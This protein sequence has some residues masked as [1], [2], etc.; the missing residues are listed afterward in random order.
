MSYSIFQ[1]NINSYD[2]P[3]PVNSTG[4]NILFTDEH[5]NVNGWTEKIIMPNKNPFNTV[6][7]IRWHLLNYTDD[8]YAI[9]TDGSIEIKNDP[10]K[11]IDLMKNS[12]SDFAII[13]HPYRTN[14]YD[15]YTEWVR[16]R[17]YDKLKAFSWLAYMTDNG[18]NPKQIGLYQSTIMIFRN[19]D[20]VKEFCNCVWNMLHI[21]D[22][23]NVERLDQTVVSFLLKTK[24]KDMNLLEL[25]KEIMNCNEFALHWKH[26]MK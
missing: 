12:N 11:W 16:I 8:E 25:P 22:K 7:D 17:N 21:F 13:Q 2:M 18:W 26:P 1:V 20:K 24:F 10:R 4:N 23:D 14:I 6:F 3:F 15:E 5:K 9:W 19:C